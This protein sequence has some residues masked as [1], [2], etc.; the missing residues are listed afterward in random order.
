M[1]VGFLSPTT[2]ATVETVLASVDFTSQTTIN[3]TNLLSDTYKYYNLRFYYTNG[4]V[5]AQDIYFRFR[6][7]T[8][9]KTAGYYCGITQ[10]S[11][12]GTITST[13]SQNNGGAFFLGNISSSNGG[14]FDMRITRQSASIGFMN[15][16]AISRYTDASLSGTG[17]NTNMSNLT[18]FTIFITSGTISGNYLLTGV[19]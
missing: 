10:T 17:V 2:Y 6:E 14:N 3:V 11:F 12:T 4:S 19:K 16:Q 1:S 18:G 7:N 5:N 9:D 13:G 15:Y 8:T